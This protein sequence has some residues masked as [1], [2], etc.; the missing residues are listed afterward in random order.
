MGLVRK[1]KHFPTPSEEKEGRSVWGELR[2]RT[3]VSEALAGLLPAAGRA[4]HVPI[5]HAVHLPALLA[6]SPGLPVRQ[7][8]K[9]QSVR[10]ILW[11]FFA[12]LKVP[13]KL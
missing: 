6:L 13:G 2:A 9:Q 4:P 8:R 5:L 10:M 3:S 7:A 12:D 1:E 11:A